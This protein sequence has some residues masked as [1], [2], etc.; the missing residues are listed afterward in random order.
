VRIVDPATGAPLPPGGDGEICVRGPTLFS[1]YWRQE[2]GECVDPEGFFHTGDRGRLDDRGALHFL[3]RL[4][5]VIKTAGVNVAAAEV[6]AALLEHPAV[7]A[8]HVVP[9]P[10][11]ARGENVAA[12]VVLGAPASIEEL[13]AHCRGRLATYKVP[14][15]LW[16]RRDDE[17]PLKGSGKVDKPRLRAVAADLVA[18][19]RGGGGRSGSLPGAP[20]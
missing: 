19:L 14:H 10:D 7:A 9:V 2:P 15:H 6:E 1:H 5:D 8:A 20:A 13:L 17:L 11:P 12:F 4:K 16:V 3:G 18:A